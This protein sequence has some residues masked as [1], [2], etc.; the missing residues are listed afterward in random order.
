MHLRIEHTTEYRYP[1]PSVDSHNEVRLVP[2]SDADQAVH[3][4][5]LVTQP[6][7]T[8]VGRS[9]PSGWV[10][11]FTVREPHDRLA[12]TLRADVETTLWD[13]FPRVNLVNP[14][15]VHYRSARL[16]RE[17]R[18]YL[19]PTIYVPT[20]PEVARLAAPFFQAEIPVAECLF[21]WMRWIHANF[22]Y[23]TDATHVQTTLPEVLVRRAG[24]C[25]DLTHLMLAGCRE[26]GIPCRYVSGYLYVGDDPTMRGEQATHAWVE[27]LMPNGTW[28]GLD[29]TNNLAANDHFVRVHFGRDY[30]DVS[31]TMGIYIGGPTQSL[32]VHVSVTAIDPATVDPLG[33]TPPAASPTPVRT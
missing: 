27:C 30:A 16:R 3:G 24:V 26:H 10:H 6:A 29:P 23:D 18:A 12:I 32:R 21:N 11:T 20:S 31:P 13:P 2:F 28:Y 14:D 33:A 25:Q 19:E 22:E 4:W 17:W 15:L 9:T 1:W 7:A 5:E 8:V